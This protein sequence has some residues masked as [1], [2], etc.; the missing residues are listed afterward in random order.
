MVS[1]G[2]GVRCDPAGCR[3]TAIEADRGAGGPSSQA[4]MEPAAVA[5]GQCM[6]RVR[7]HLPSLLPPAPTPYHSSKPR[8]A[9]IELPH[10]HPH[11]FLAL[12]AWQD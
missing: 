8:P 5:L 10:S 7:G 6:G 1:V 3:G 9:V 11:E 12:P 2:V 4:W